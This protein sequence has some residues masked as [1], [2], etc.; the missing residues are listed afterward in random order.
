MGSTWSR[1]T[2]VNSFVLPGRMLHSTTRVNIGGISFREVEVLG[3][4]KLSAYKREHVSPR[5]NPNLVLIQSWVNPPKMVHSSSYSQASKKPVGSHR[6]HEMARTTIIA[7]AAKADRPITLAS[8][9]P[10]GASFSRAISA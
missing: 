3:W 7:P 10:R 5:Q 6:C 8:S 4:K 2:L 9:S 1:T